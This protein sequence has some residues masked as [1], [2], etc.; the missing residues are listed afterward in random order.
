MKVTFANNKLRHCF[1]DNGQAQREWNTAV[2]RKYIQRIQL[3]LD[4]PAF[5]ELRKIRSLRLHS[6]HGQMT[7]Q[8]A[9]DLN[10]RW[11]VILTY[12]EDEN[13]VLISEVTNHYGD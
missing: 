8:F 2:A 3:I 7:G 6:L 1:E 11:R 5:S 13:S 12:N 10:N 9:I 4:T